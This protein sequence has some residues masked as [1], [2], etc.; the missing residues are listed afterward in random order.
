MDDEQTGKIKF[1][2][3]FTITLTAA[4]LHTVYTALES[5]GAEIISTTAVCNN[6]RKVGIIAGISAWEDDKD[7]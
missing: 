3:T 4:Q 1:T 6:P 5:L 7:D 2:T